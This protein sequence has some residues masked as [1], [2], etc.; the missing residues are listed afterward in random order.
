MSTLTQ[1][2][3][4]KISS[5][6]KDHVLPK[7]LGNEESACSIAA[8]NLS[9]YGRLTDEIPE[10]MSRVIGRWIIRVQDAMPYDMRNSE[11]WKRLLPLA[12]GTGRDHEQERKDI[13]L[14]WMWR[15][16]LPY[17]LPLA[18]ENGFGEQWREMCEKKDVGAATAAYAYADATASYAAAAAAT[19]AAYTAA[20]T[21]ASYAAAASDAASY[22]AAATAAHAATAAAADD[23]AASDAAWKHFNPCGLLQKLIEVGE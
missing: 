5:Y 18:E 9:L 20:A 17:L 15:V 22:A 11:E 1:I 2:E 10:C 8:I 21:D 12:A 13:I 14:D 7:G 6:L 19:Y 16:V 3:R 4:D 23:D